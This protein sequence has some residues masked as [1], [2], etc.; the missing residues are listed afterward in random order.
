MAKRARNFDYSTL[1]PKRDASAA[2]FFAIATR[3]ATADFHA[4]DQKGGEKP[5]WAQKNRVAA[6]MTA[7]HAESG[8]KMTNGE[9]NKLFEADRLPKKYRDLFNPEKTNGG[10]NDDSDN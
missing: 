6:V 3:F 9:A 1:D 7:Y 4:V 2:R 5:D 10:D 8:K